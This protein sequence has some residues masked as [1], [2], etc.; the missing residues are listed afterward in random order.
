MRR[1]CFA[2]A[3][4]IMD[5]VA[6]ERLYEALDQIISRENHLEFWYAGCYDGFETLA[7]EYIQR[8]RKA[9]PSCKVEII[10]VM[11]PLKFEHP[12]LEEIP[13]EIIA[14]QGFPLGVVSR[15]EFA[16]RLEGKAEMHE[17][18]FVTH[19]RKVDRWVMHQCDTLLVFNYDSI[20]GPITN[21]VR[22]IQK[23]GNMTVI[24]IFNPDRF[25]I[26]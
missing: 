1:V 23:K 13:K 14:E 20:P 24:P 17:S 8:I 22:Q 6:K 21:M 19:S 11:D 18:R 2:G 9:Y 26:I 15:T 5:Q 25:E 3:A 10:A 12:A 7:L 16:P 4:Y